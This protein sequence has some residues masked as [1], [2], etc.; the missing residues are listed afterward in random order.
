MAL[1]LF[2]TIAIFR[3][4]SLCPARAPVPASVR[5]ITCICLYGSIPRTPRIGPMTR[6]LFYA[7]ACASAKAESKSRPADLK[8]IFSFTNRAASAAPY[9]RSIPQSSHSTER[10]PSYPT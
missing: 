7:L 3:H 2:E 4:V 8:P 1:L 5:L 10:G 6:L 9:S